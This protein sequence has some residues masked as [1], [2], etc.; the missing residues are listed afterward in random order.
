MKKHLTSPKF[1]KCFII[2]YSLV[3]FSFLMVVLALSAGNIMAVIIAVIACLSLVLIGLN[4]EKNAFLKFWV[5]DEGIHNKY[6]S[7]NW[8][9]IKS[10]NICEVYFRYNRTF[11][12]QCPSVLCLGVYD[13]NKTF[14]KQD[15]SKCI[16]ISMTPQ[17]FELLKQYKD[18][19]K[20]I[21][22]VIELYSSVI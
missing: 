7:I 9:E 5:N 17:Y 18:S 3:I 6:Y 10:Y 14:S 20:V 2:A 1:A 4:K 8:E 12:I 16:F 21:C 11:K 22:E 19:S 15:P 13:S